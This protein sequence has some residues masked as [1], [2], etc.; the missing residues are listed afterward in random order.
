MKK[1]IAATAISVAILVIGG[2]SYRAFLAKAIQAPLVEAAVDPESV[3]FR[4]VKMVGDWTVRGT[5]MCGEMNA[6][7]RTGGYEGFQKFAI[8]GADAP[9]LADDEMVDAMCSALSTPVPWWYIR[10]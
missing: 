5:M 1:L 9:V 7:N 4:H 10:G 2:V 3:R 8:L 6:R